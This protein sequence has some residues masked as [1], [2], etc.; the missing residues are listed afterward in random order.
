MDSDWESNS[1]SSSTSS[2]SSSSS[3]SLSSS[4]SSYKMIKQEVFIWVDSEL[5]DIYKIDEKLT[6]VEQKENIVTKLLPPLY[7]I[8]NKKY[9]ITNRKLLKMLYG[10]WRSRH[11]TSNIKNQGNE[12]VKQNKR[13]SSKNSRMQE[14]KKRRAHATNYLIENKNKYILRYLEED[15]VKIL[16]DSGYHSEEWEETDPEEEWPITQS[17]V[18]EDDEIIEEAIKQK[19]S[20][21]YIHNKWWRSPALLRLLHD[22]IDPT[23]ELLKKKPLT[24]K[25]KRAQSSQSRYNTSNVPPIGV[26]S[27]CLNQNA[28]EQFNYSNVNIPVYDYNTDD[29]DNSDNDIEDENNN[30]EEIQNRIN[31]SKKKK[32]KTKK[33]SNQKKNKKHK[34]K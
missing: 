27:W 5:K 20:S 34:S 18:V 2:S 8:V 11:R 33:R 25:R 29:Q 22:R 26:P 12:R 10:W 21:I 16:K 3:S 14:K 7:K 13:R 1:S 28:L 31:S 30:E 17:A 6:W 9:S 23:V 4:S 15:L 24:L 19:S 32:K